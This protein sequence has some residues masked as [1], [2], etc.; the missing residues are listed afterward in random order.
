ME[1]QQG[2]IGIRRETKTYWE[3]RVA[4]TPQ[5]VKRLINEGI[6]VL[7]Q[8]STNRCF[9]DIEFAEAGAELT[10]DLTPA[11]LIIGVKEIPTDELI[12][13]RTYM[14]F[15]HTLKGQPYNMPL[16]DAF[17]EKQIRLI[18]YECI[19][20]LEP[21]HNRLVAF[22]TFAGSAGMVDFLQGLGKYLLMKHISTPFLL[23][24]FA[25]M[26]RSLADIYESIEHIGEIISHDGFHPSVVPMIFGVTGNGRCA[27]GAL[28]ILTKLPH[29][30][31]EPEQLENFTP[32]E[33]SRFKIYI[34]RFPI[35]YIYRRFSDDGFDRAEYQENPEMYKSVFKKYAAKLSCL[36]HAIYWDSKYPKMLTVDDIKT[37]N[38]RLLG[39]CDIS[40]DIKGGIQI[41]RKF[42]SPEEPFYLYS[43]EDDR[44]HYLS[45]LHINNSILY[46]SM[47]FLSSELPRDASEHFS[48]LLFDYIEELAWDDAN[49]SFEEINLNP[50]IKNAIMTCHGQLTPGFRYITDIRRNV[51]TPVRRNDTIDKIADVVRE[52]PHLASDLENTM[53]KQALT[54]ESERAVITI[55]EIIKRK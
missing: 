9:S 45:S 27:S 51:V 22:G 11:K 44:I 37:L 43:S 10:E 54:K 47:D 23:Q 35:R 18:D 34:V 7:V 26:Y 38:G 8:P 50:E 25:Y 20:S 52:N 31:I 15:S 30:F 12:P 14:L 48:K 53:N 33:Q 36:V 28:N 32:N 13:N 40:C 29:E 3:R 24:G 19:K 5:D 16:L 46:H 2:V 17:L 6:R 39:I 4:I 21:P 55:R 1:G 41:C 42:T 49:K